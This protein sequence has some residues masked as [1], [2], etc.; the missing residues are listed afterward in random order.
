MRSANCFQSSYIAMDGRTTRGKAT[1]SLCTRMLRSIRRRLIDVVVS[2]A[3]RRLS[4]EGLRQRSAGVGRGLTRLRVSVWL[5]RQQS[6]SHGAGEPRI[7]DIHVHRVH[8]D[9]LPEV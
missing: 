8:R 1:M 7:V 6:L 3:L 2:L 9:I 4:S 5:H